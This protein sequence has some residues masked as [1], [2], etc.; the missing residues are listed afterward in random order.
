MNLEAST[1]ELVLH[2]DKRLLAAIQ[3]VVMSA[4]EYASLSEAA[5]EDLTRAADEACEEAFSLAGRNGSSD[6][7]IKV[8]IT[9]FSDRVEI[10]VEHAGDSCLKEH[11]KHIDRVECHVHN[12]RSRST[13]IKYAAA[14]K[15]ERSS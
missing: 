8:A 10:A 4:S 2:N 3:A 13:L 12:G 1:T 5:R 15:S 9:G 11:R 14:S 7:V 6:P